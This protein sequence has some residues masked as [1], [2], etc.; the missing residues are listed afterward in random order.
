[1][2][3]NELFTLLRF[4]NKVGIEFL[5]KPPKGDCAP[6]S[7][8]KEVQWLGEG[9]SKGARPGNQMSAEL[10]KKLEQVSTLG[11][12]R[13]LVL[14]FDGCSLKEGA[15]NTVFCDGNPD[16]GIMLIGEAPGEQEDKL[17]IPFR[18]RSGNLLDKMLQAIDLDRKKVYITN[19]IFWRPPGNRRPLPEEIEACRP[20]LEHHIRLVSPKLIVLLGSTA[21]SS[22][23]NSQD[24]VSQMRNRFH[25]YKNDFIKEAITT[26]VTFHPSYLLRQPAQKRLAWEDLKL[27]RS[28]IEEHAI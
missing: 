18:G 21:A 12:L 19:T 15:T 17:G 16:S 5:R 9:Q 7:T 6:F 25:Q 2:S 23:L 14:S 8:E 27:I 13:E 4:Y 24:R 10:A 20:F 3:L 26:M 1:M 22:V 11:E 28:Y